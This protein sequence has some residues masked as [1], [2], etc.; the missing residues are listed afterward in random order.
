MPTGG[1]RK[2]S[3][4]GI[5]VGSAAGGGEE[6]A[7]A[8]DGNGSAAET[9]MSDFCVDSFD[10][11]T[12]VTSAPVEN[13]GYV[14]TWAFTNAGSKYIDRIASR[15]ANFEWLEQAGGSYWSYS[16]GTGWGINDY[17]A[18]LQTDHS[19]YKDYSFTIQN[20]TRSDV[21]WKQNIERMGTSPTGLPIFEFEY[22]NTDHGKGRFRGTTAQELIKHDRADATILDKDG[23]YLVDYNKIDIIFESC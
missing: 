22:I 15:A 8:A 10:G 18:T 1:N 17:N 12:L 5:A 23:Y 3:Y 19:S 20:Q 4:L 9:K 6:T 14:A 7:L 21:R 16:G 13:Y 2:L 11:A